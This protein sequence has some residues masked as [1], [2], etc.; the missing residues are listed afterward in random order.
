MLPGGHTYGQYS[1]TY[2][3]SLDGYIED[4]KGGFDWACRPRGAPLVT[5]SSGPIGT[6]LYGRRMYETMAVWQTVRD[7]P[8]RAA[9]AG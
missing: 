5:T 6:H 2:S 3:A 7:E 4:D 8:G 9:A 1:S